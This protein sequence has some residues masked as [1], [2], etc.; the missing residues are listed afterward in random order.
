MLK[1]FT[2]DSLFE[3]GPAD[4]L[5]DVTLALLQDLPQA[6][7]HGRGHDLR[8]GAGLQEGLAQVPD[9][10]VFLLAAGQLGRHHVVGDV[11]QGAANLAGTRQC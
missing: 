2:S 1:N 3:E 9:D 10:H 5:H 11:L 4:V 7:H 6:S 8:A